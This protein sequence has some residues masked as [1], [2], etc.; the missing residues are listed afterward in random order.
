[1]S[2]ARE[3]HLDQPLV[4]TRRLA[5]TLTLCWAAIG[6]AIGLVVT[7]AGQFPD[8]VPTFV[9]PLDGSPTS[10]APSVFPIVARVP[11]MGAA[12]L[13]VVSSLAYGATLSGGWL[14]FFS[15]MAIAITAKTWLETISLVI[16][17]TPAETTLA[18]PL[19]LLTLGIVAAFVAYALQA[20]RRG[21]LKM[22]PENAGSRV[23]VGVGVGIA[24]WLACAMLPALY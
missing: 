3:P 13:L 10:W 18:L 12:Q 9:S 22:T 5:R 21:H 2:A 8:S 19:H 4:G 1:M 14:R 20:W 6:A 23:W 16:V 7:R 17:G 15:W 11:A 24:L